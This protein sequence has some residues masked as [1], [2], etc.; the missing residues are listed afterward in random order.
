MNIKDFFYEKFISKI[1]AENF[2]REYKVNEE[3]E[4]IIGKSNFEDLFQDTGLITNFYKTDYIF[5]KNNLKSYNSNIKN[6]R[7]IFYYKGVKEAKEKGIQKIVNYTNNIETISGE[8]FRNGNIKCKENRNTVEHYYLTG[9]IEKIEIYDDSKTVKYSYSYY[10]SGQLKARTTLLNDKK[11]GLSQFYR[12]DGLLMDE[13]FFGNDEK[14]EG[15]YKKFY[16]NGQI[17]I[18]ADYYS[19]KRHGYYK[20]YY[21]NGQL[22]EIS[23]Y[24]LDRKIKIIAMYSESG[25]EISGANQ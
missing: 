18:L 6:G 15:V 7:A 16:N 19:G 12:E 25:V 1:F 5:S 21:P 22:K 11:I 23:I 8:Y 17:H 10:K 4:N 20:E 9:E 13:Y 14:Y 24:D 2:L 3:K